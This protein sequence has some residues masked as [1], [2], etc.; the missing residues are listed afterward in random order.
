MQ[1]YG[2]SMTFE[3]ALAQSVSACFLS[4][5]GSLFVLTIPA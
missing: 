2:P 5:I 3:I 1:Y 4:S